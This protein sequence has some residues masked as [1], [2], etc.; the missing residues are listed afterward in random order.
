MLRTSIGFFSGLET[1]HAHDTPKRL[2]AHC[3]RWV[4]SL[5]DEGSESKTCRKIPGCS[6]AWRRQAVLKVCE[7]IKDVLFRDVAQTQRRLSIA[8]ENCQD[9]IKGPE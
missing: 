8:I 7:G 3:F 2:V 6:H 4:L 1:Y 9:M 5:L